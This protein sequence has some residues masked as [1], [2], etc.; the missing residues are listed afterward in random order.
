MRNHCH[1]IIILTTSPVGR[2][3]VLKNEQLAAWVLTHSYVI[4]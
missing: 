4:Y 1:I 2:D 3:E